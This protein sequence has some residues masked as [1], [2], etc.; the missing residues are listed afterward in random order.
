VRLFVHIGAAALSVAL[1]TLPRVATA[2]AP[3]QGQ[4]GPCG[5][6]GLAQLLPLLLIFAVFYFL[7]IRPQQ[8]RE[9]Q[10]Q[11]MLADLKKGDEVVTT[12]G[13]VGR[14]TGISDNIVIL[15]LQEK[16]RVRVMRSHISGKSSTA[17]SAT[18]EKK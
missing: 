17:T 14:I 9:K 7:L 10:R 13:L 6:A 18:P 16:V 12:G 5:G 8:K 4:G 3:G 15:E 1:T 11:Q 2:Q